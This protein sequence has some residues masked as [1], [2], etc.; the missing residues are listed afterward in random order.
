MHRI[1]A[2]AA[3]ALADMAQKSVEYVSEITGG[4][5][6]YLIANA[7]FVSELSNYS[8]IGDLCVYSART[9]KAPSVE[10]NGWIAP[11]SPKN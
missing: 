3:A 9:L 11:I 10:T 2:L 1:V 7:A 8:T 6:D 5:L 4:K